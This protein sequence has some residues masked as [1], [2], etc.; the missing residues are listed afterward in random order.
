MTAAPYSAT[1]ATVRKFNTE[2][3]VVAADHYH[4]PP[5]ERIDLDAVLG[6]VRDKK[7]FVLHARA[8]N[9]KSESLRLGNF[10][11]QEVR[12]LLAQHT[13][14]NG[15]A[16]TEE[17]LALVGTRT[18]GQP[19]LVNAV[20]RAHRPADRVAAGWARAA[21]H[22]GVQGAA[23]GPGAD[24]RRGGGADPRLRGPL[25]GGGGPPRRIRPCAGPNLG[26]EDVPSPAVASRRAGH[27]LG[28]VAASAT[29][30][31]VAS[32]T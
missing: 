20:L 10:S 8:F 30:A 24:H 4:V 11:E 3:P 32:C 21:L 28:A 22:G 2:E 1:M 15:Q 6:L 13:A 9:V 31:L 23:Q 27:G 25:R 12:T 29:C 26:R 18:A 5:L 14:A 17:A 19:W 7:Y 16:F